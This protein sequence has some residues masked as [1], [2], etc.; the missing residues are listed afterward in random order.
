MQPI[1][2][3]LEK[4]I[5][6]H[7]GDVSQI[8]LRPPSFGDVMSH[9][10]PVSYGYAG[11]VVYTAENIDRIRAYIK[12]LIVQPPA[13]APQ[14]DDIL[15]EQLGIVDTLRLKDAVRGFFTEARSKITKEKPTS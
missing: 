9:G 8:T 14:I 3:K 15:I 11:E 6:G 7:G 1:I 2:I 5:T 12:A 13:P 4:P 10:E